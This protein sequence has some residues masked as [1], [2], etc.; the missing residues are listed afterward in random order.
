MFL[1]KKGNSNLAERIKLMERFIHIFGLHCIEELLAD[2]EFVSTEWFA[3]LKN[4][5]FN[6]STDKT[7]F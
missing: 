1:P 6:F 3:W 7:H 5:F 4:K 2:R